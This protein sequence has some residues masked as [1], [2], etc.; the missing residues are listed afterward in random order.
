MLAS[1]T[2]GNLF[3]QGLQLVGGCFDRQ[4][5]SR[6][7]VFPASAIRRPR[8]HAQVQ[9][10]FPVDPPGGIECRQFA[11]AVSAGGIRPQVKVVQNRKHGQADRTD[12]G[13]GHIGPAKAIRL[14]LVIWKGRGAEKGFPPA[15]GVWSNWLLTAS[16]ASMAPGKQQERSLPMFIL[17]SL[18]GKHEGDFSG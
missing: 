9:K 18:S 6:I 2:S 5:G 7:A 8:V 3:D 4:H 12:G 13:L 11:V 15:D 16:T 1:T 17:A 10:G 14:L